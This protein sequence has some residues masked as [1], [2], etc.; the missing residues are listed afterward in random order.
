VRVSY[1]CGVLLIERYRLSRRNRNPLEEII[2]GLALRVDGGRP[3]VFEWL[4]GPLLVRDGCTLY[5]LPNRGGRGRS[6]SIKR[7]DES[8][9]AE[10]T[11]APGIVL[12]AQVLEYPLQ[13]YSG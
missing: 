8:Y 4:R 12:L 2:Y 7:R 3:S 5:R 6:Q 10:G 11:L 1:T 9:L 13:M